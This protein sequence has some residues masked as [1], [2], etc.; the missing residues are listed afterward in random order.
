MSRCLVIG[1]GFLGSHVAEQLASDGHSIVIYSRSFNPWLLR[2]DR[3]GRGEIDLVEGQLPAGAGLRELI[4]DAD[5]VFYLSGSSTPAMAHTDP[6]GSIL[7]SVVPAAAVF[8]LMRPTSTRRIVVASSGG[9]VYGS[10][11][12]VPT[13]EDHP[14]KPTS[15]HGHNSLTIERYAAF[16][17]EQHGFE[18]II[19]RY[20]NPYGPGQ[21]ARRGQGVIAAW[22]ERLARGDTVVLYGNPGTRRDFVFVDDAATATVEAAFADA[23]PA[24]YNVGA[25]E[26][27]SLAE[28]LEQ[29]QLAAGREA[30]V[31]RVARRSVDLPVTELDCTRLREVTGWEPKTAL[32]VGIKASW[33]WSS[34]QPYERRA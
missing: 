22:C 3:S 6:G 33:N 15:I 13:N 23:A 20:S 32:P 12:S 5:V 31:E 24:I 29:I 14:T 30:T 16:F 21:L 34:Q 19:V 27:W 2:E 7:S 9:T 8:D 18:P 4:D 26:S 28:V 25:G 11:N 17:A 1:G 10:V